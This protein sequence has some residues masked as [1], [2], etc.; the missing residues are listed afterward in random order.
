MRSADSVEQLA[1]N[2]YMLLGERV[3]KDEERL[4]VK[5]VIERV[6]S[7]RG[8]SV[9]IDPDVLYASSAPEIAAVPNSPSQPIVWTK[10]MRRLFM[11]VSRALQNN[12]PVLLVGETGC[13]KTTVCQ[14]L[15]GIAGRQLHTVNAHRNTETADIV[16]SQRPIR[17]RSEAAKQLRQK[18]LAALGTKE[19]LTTEILLEKYQEMAKANG[20]PPSAEIEMLRRK[21]KSLFQWDDGPLVCA[22]K[23]GQYFLID[24]ISLAEDSVLERINSVLE[25]DRS[26]FLAEMGTKN[27][28][29]RA[30]DGFQLMATMNPGGDYGKRELSPALR[31]RFTEIWVPPLADLEDVLEITRATL[32]QP[33]L[34]DPLIGFAKWFSDNFNASSMSAISVRDILTCVE[35]INKFPSLDASVCLLDAV[36]MV[37]V[38]TLGANPAALLTLSSSLSEQRTKC[39]EQLERLIGVENLEADY[40]ATPGLSMSHDS[41]RIGRFELTRHSAVPQDNAFTFKAKTTKRN[42]MRIARALQL[43][44]PILI[45]GDPGV[46]KT[47]LVTSIARMVGKNLV[48]INLSEQTDLMDLFGSD[49]PV[50]AAGNFAWRDAPFLAAMKAGDWVLLDE[51]N[52]APQSILEGLNACFDHRG[53]AYI[54]ELNQTFHRHAGFRVFAAQN[55]HHQGGGRK[56]LPASFVNRF[57]VV[58]ADAFTPEDVRVICERIF[59]DTDASEIDSVAKVVALV[60]S[61]DKQINR[62]G[63]SGAPW[64]VNLRDALRWLLLRSDKHVFMSAATAYDL[65]DV[66][67]RRRFRT[68]EDMRRMDDIYAAAFDSKAEARGFY[69]DLSP[70]VAQVGIAIMDR[71]PRRA[72]SRAPSIGLPSSHLP[73]LEAMIFAVEYTWPVVLVGA[74]GS[75]KTN[76]LRHLSARAGKDLVVLPMNSDIDATDLI[77]GFEQADNSRHY[78]SVISRLRRILEDLIRRALKSNKPVF[79]I[80]ALDILSCLSDVSESAIG[81]IYAKTKA[82]FEKHNMDRAP[83]TQRLLDDLEALTR[84]PSGSIPGFRWVD[85]PLVQA[86]ERGDWL[87]LDNANLCSSS[88]LDRLNSLLEPGGTLVINENSLP[89]GKT[90]VVK[91]QDT[92]RIFLTMDPVHGELSNAM[93]NRSLELFVPAPDASTTVLDLPL[94]S[95]AYNLE[96]VVEVASIATRDKDDLDYQRWGELLVDHISILKIADGEVE[97]RRHLSHD[98][99]GLLAECVHPKIVHELE[100]RLKQFDWRLSITESQIN[101]LRPVLETSAFPH[102]WNPM[103]VSKPYDVFVSHSK[104]PLNPLNN[105]PMMRAAFPGWDKGELFSKLLDVSMAVERLLDQVYGD[106]RPLTDSALTVSD[107]KTSTASYFHLAM[108]K[109]LRGE[110]TVTKVSR[111]Y[112]DGG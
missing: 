22:M 80:P 54:A 58:Y 41:V 89:N 88:V 94:E 17:N 107:F 73:I 47:A 38:D 8:P 98:L 30:A 69:H 78:E 66:V 43:P 74:G 67:F 10:S 37:F 9:R 50:G 12:E 92:F 99:C 24:E 110:A 21:V 34:S 31:N 3:R 60:A 63:S 75:G 106:A 64:E 77:G 81:S 35:F 85:G 71:E 45:E 18:L 16:G 82:Y 25:P 90:R 59:P 112:A 51:M 72:A 5:E 83:L 29:I 79:T 15:A 84:A 14:M 100:R 57:T 102:S 19:N 95:V 39:I 68:D 101:M 91:P 33:A 6:M 111:T 52:L 108:I 11:L 56:G 4:A 42:A 65:F 87:V 97:G 2:G 76:L 32:D 44:K 70:T 86:V 1:T 46:G 109:M 20:S 27:A 23:S 13:G 103:V 53:E 48:R 36:S 55:P 7:Q 61:G 26:I 49:V 62:L 96:K 104:Q 28:H 93:R 105:N 40:Q